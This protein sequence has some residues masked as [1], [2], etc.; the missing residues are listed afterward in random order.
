MRH[1]APIRRQ[2]LVS[3]IAVT[4]LLS[5]VI[6]ATHVT[7]ARREVRRLSSALTERT[8]TEMELR[9]GGFFAPVEDEL[10]HLQSHGASGLLDLERVDEAIDLLAPM[11]AR[12]RQIRAVLVADERGRELRLTR[13]GDG[14]TARETRVEDGAAARREPRGSAEH[15]GYDPRQRP[16]YRQAM[17]GSDADAR[18]TEPYPFFETGDP[19]ITASARF[20]RGD[21]LA[22]VVA[23]DVTLVDISTFTMALRPTQGGRAMVLTE[24]LALVGLPGDPGLASPESRRA[25][26][27]SPPEAIDV[28]FIADAVHAL[29][30]AEDSGPSRFRSSG[31]PWWSAATLY[32]LSPERRLWIIALVPEADL[33]GDRTRRRSLIAA[34]VIGA[35]AIAVGVAFRLARRI[36]EPIEALV[37]QSERIRQGDLGPGEIV[38]ARVAEVE[39]LVHAQEEMRS[40]LQALWKIEADLSVARDIQR[41]TF[42]ECLP[43]LPGFEIDAWLEPAE[44]T[45]GDSYDVIGYRRGPEPHTVQLTAGEAE[46]AVLLMADATGHGIG[47]ALSATQV[48]SMLRMAVR[49]GEPLA[50]IVR[51]LNDQL[52]EDLGSG[53]FVTAWLGELDAA[54][55]TLRSF[56]AGQAPVLVW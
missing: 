27:L 40:A 31:A 14:W 8:I 52:H 23:I 1:P 16:W 30:T 10:A 6:V 33:L 3:W 21:G 28:A 29:E 54:T 50:N 22:R 7:A 49:T 12:H 2:L 55:G 38:P 51:H 5:A 37:R 47:P 17:A 34:T 43:T 15:D 18:W 4:A 25:A 20:E 48:R 45:A 9:L 53:R 32:E 19:G 44:Q 24:G 36:S 46:R 26:L 13:H 41:D 42:P 11:F 35:F 56:S 39:A